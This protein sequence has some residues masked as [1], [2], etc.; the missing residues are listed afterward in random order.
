MIAKNPIT[1]LLTASL[2]SGWTIERLAEQV[3][4]AIASQESQGERATIEFALDGN[5]ITDRQSQRLMRPLVACLAQKSATEDG[6]APNLYEGCLAFQRPSLGDP[7]WVVGEFKNT[8]EKVFVTLRRSKSPPRDE[9]P[10]AR[11]VAA[12]SPADDRLGD[13]PPTSAPRQCR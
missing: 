9:Q 7:V 12:M 8:P 5:T 1:D 3:I 2:D 6:T 10:A 4:S 13:S 11:Q